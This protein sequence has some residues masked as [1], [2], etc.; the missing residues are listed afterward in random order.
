M[1]SASERLVH[2]PKAGIN[3]QTLNITLRNSHNL[4]SSEGNQQAV[5]PKNYGHMNQNLLGQR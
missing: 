2:S 5:S 4:G 1:A 3:S